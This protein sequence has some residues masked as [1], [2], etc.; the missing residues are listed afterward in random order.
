MLSNFIKNK[1]V[2]TIYLCGPTVYDYSHIGN[3]RPILTFDLFIKGLKGLNKKVNF[4]HNITDIDDKIIN[5]AIKEK[6]TEKNISQYYLQQYLDLLKKY[7]IKKPTKL[8]KVSDYITRIIDYIKNLVN[9]CYAYK[10][11]DGIF[12]DV[13]KCKYYGEISNQ[14]LDKIIQ[15]EKQYDKKNGFDF[16]LWKTTTLGLKFD[17]PFGLGRPGWHTECAVF[18]ASYFKKQIDIHGGG[19]DLIFPHHENENAQHRQLYHQKISKKFI[20]IGHLFWQGQ[21]MSK[22]LNNLIYA[23][24]FDPNLLRFIIFSNS[25]YKPLILDNDKLSLYEK[26]LLKLKKSYYYA[27]FNNNDPKKTNS[28]RIKND[29]LK[30][31]NLYLSK[32]LFANVKNILDILVTNIYKNKV[33]FDVFNDI[34]NYLGFK[35]RKPT[36]TEIEYFQDFKK[37]QKIKD[38]RKADKYREKLMKRDLI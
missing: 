2:I 33:N 28:L 20:H 8:V 35:F 12:F 17:S 19:I 30:K 21:K 37:Y 4:L 22:S 31:I 26:Q 11:K 29:Y 7:N 38:Y 24:D 32:L 27:F 13:L 16:A 36:S 25:V 9:K 5:R 23:K 15:N 3:I 18:I 6:V 14:K 1:K 10:T 34:I